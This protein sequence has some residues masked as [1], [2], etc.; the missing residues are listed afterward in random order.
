[1]VEVGTESFQELTL[2]LQH[3]HPS[4]LGYFGSGHLGGEFIE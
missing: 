3:L 1:M 4:F 2:Y